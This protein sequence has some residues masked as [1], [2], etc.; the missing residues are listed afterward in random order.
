MIQDGGVAPGRQRDFRKAAE[1]LRKIAGETAGLPDDSLTDAQL[2][3]RLELAAD[4]LDA[5]AGGEQESDR[6]RES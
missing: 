1:S 3:D 6:D 2:R 4:V 5:T